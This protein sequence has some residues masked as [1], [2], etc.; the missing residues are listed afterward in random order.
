MGA[1]RPIANQIAAIAL[2]TARNS[3]APMNRFSFQSEQNGMVLGWHLF[4]VHGLLALVA[5]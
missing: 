2:S 4:S 3:G 1:N 5:L